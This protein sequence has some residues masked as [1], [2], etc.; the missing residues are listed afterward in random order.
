MPRGR[1]RHLRTCINLSHH[2][3]DIRHR[4]NPSGMISQIST[5][6]ICIGHEGS[7]MADEW[8]EE[9]RL[10]RRRWFYLASVVA[11]LGLSLLAY[12]WTHRVWTLHQWYVYQA[13]EA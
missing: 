6:P 11:V 1:A 3:S 10:R 7:A 4:S 2:E 12:C 9:P 13:M 5:R 8:I